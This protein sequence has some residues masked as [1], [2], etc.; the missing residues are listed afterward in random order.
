MTSSQRNAIFL[1]SI[2]VAGCR[3]DIE[4]VRAITDNNTHPVQ[5]SYDAVYSF[6]EK[7]KKQTRLEATLLEQFELEGDDDY[8]LASNG[9]RMI[10]FD[11][12][13]QEDARIEARNGKY[14][15]KKKLLTAWD[16]VVLTNKAGEKLETEELIYQ[17]DS[18][19]IVTDKQVTIT[20]SGGTVLRGRGLES[21]D[22]FTQYRII[23]PTGDIMVEENQDSTHGKNQ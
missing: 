10:F 20:L 3:N 22:S 5:T 9:F 2:V 23:Q 21:N 12:S 11:S 15:E 6:S 8:L 1:I 17:Q 14:E 13:E 16:S 4:Q 18:A 7:G 19:R